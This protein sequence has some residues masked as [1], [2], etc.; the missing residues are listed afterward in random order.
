M[1]RIGDIGCKPLVVGIGGTTRAN[2]GSERAVRCALRHAEEAGARTC[3]CAGPDI[4]FPIYDPARTNRT[5]KEAL[6]VNL[7]RKAD[8]II[9]ASPGYHGSISGLLKNALDYTQ[10]MC[11]DKK[12]YFS[13]RAVGCIGIAG[14][15]Q[16]AQATL[17]TLRDIVHALRGWPTPLGVTINSAGPPI[18]DDEANCLDEDLDGRLRYMARQVVVFGVMRFTARAAY[19]DWEL[20]PETGEWFP[21]VKIQ[22]ADT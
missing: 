9:L 14:G 8:G 22:R 2:S 1:N 10:D 12:A 4:T 21:K 18:F 17:G 20:W 16:A 6:F 11:S 13:A 7:L 15:W 3:I 5:E 19:P